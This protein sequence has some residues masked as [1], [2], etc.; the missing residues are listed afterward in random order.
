MSPWV[1]YAG[2]IQQ[3]QTAFLL[4]AEVFAYPMRKEADRIWRCIDFVFEPPLHLDREQKAR[5]ILSEIRDRM[6]VYRD[7]RKLK[8]PTGMLKRIGITPPRKVNNGEP[9]TAEFTE[10]SPVQFGAGEPLPAEG[11]IMGVRFHEDL[12]EEQ[13]QTPRPSLTSGSSAS[14]SNFSSSNSMFMA[15]PAEMTLSDDMMNDIDWV[16]FFRVERYCADALLE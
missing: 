9:P 14:S 15:P 1:W 11:K 5:L 13:A 3:Y 16:S 8:A 4:L 7:A 6:S 12:P 2:A 10:P